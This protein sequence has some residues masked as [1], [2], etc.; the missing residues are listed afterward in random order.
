LRKLPIAA[1]RPKKVKYPSPRAKF[2]LQE[3]P[4]A[5]SVLDAFR[6]GRECNP[7]PK[8]PARPLDIVAA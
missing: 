1:G 8:A 7:L 2:V 5:A 6:E 4:A 3:L